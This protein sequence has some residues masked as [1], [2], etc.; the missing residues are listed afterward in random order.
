MIER[1]Y[2]GRALQIV[3]SDP[4]TYV[5]GGLILQLV[6]AVAL[7]LLLGPAI[8]GIVWITLKHLRGQ[9]VAFGDLFRGFDNFSDA[10]VAGLA[11]ALLVG[12]GLVLGVVPGIVL[13]ALFCFVFPFVVDRDLPFPEA[14]AASR[15]I[16]GGGDL[17]DRGLFFL[18]ALL[19]GLSGVILGVV[20]LLFTWPLMW[21]TV[22][23]A[24]EDLTAAQAEP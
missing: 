8:C 19:V 18:L 1:G 14:M 10:L 16:A 9:K 2:F 15:R 5:I 7:G 6:A 3:A 20:G 11:F 24:Y 12:A 22:A 21:A 4:A 13:G 23:V 17:L